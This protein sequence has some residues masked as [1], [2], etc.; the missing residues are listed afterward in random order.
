MLEEAKELLSEVEGFS[1]KNTE[2]LEVFRIRF[3][4]KKGVMNDLFSA[5]KTIPNKQKKDFGQA[6]NQLKQVA[7]KKLMIIRFLLKAPMMVKRI[8]I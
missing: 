8:L 6:L 3:F 5:F 1:P 4:G 7:Q 2:E